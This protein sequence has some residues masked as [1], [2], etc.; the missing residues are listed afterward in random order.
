VLRYAAYPV[1]IT[2]GKNQIGDV[3]T[4]EP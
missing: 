1:R 2:Y 3:L 4:L